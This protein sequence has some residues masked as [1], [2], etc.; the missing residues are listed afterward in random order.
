M[1]LQR[2]N[3]GI[4]IAA[5]SYSNDEAFFHIEAKRLP[6]PKKQREREYVIGKG[7]GG[8]ERF[9]KGK[10]GYGLKYSAMIG[11]IQKYDFKYWEKTI[12]GW[13]SNEIQS[14]KTSDLK[15]NKSENLVK[16]DCTEVIAELISEHWRIN[17]NPIKLYHLWVTLH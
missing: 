7:N 4:I 9:K 15:W 14:D 8:I 5:K 10:H 1:L 12:N 13:I 3:E 16:T 6:T 11:Y 17:Q 2:A